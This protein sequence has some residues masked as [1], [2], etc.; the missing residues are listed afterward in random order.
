MSGR[1]GRAFSAVMGVVLAQRLAHWRGIY[2]EELPA[3]S[4][5]FQLTVIAHAATLEGLP[6]ITPEGSAAWN[7]H[8][9]EFR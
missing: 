6:Q 1:W 4:L 3:I 7:V 8:E 9:W 5:Y 2:S